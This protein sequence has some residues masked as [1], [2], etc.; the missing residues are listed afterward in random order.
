MRDYPLSGFAEDAKKKL[1]E[2]EMTVPE[3]D[4][5]ALNRMKWERENRVKPGLVSRS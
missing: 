4:P 2:L 5:V 1:K 3:A